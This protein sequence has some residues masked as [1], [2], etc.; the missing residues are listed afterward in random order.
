[1]TN[2][3]ILENTET[4]ERFD[5]VEKEI[6]DKNDELIKEINNALTNKD[7]LAYNYL[8]SL[9]LQCAAEIRLINYIK[10]GCK[11]DFIIC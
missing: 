7:E 2:E 5:K 3:M 8:K 1:M 6:R 4:Q 11:G 9:Q 10:N